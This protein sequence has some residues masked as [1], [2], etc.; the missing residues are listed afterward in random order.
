MLQD[1]EGPCDPKTGELLEQGAMIPRPPVPEPRPKASRFYNFELDEET[2]RPYGKPFKATVPL[3]DWHK[4][5]IAGRLLKAIGEPKPAPAHVPLAKRLEMAAAK[6][7]K[8]KAKGD[9]KT[10]NQGVEK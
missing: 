9:K 1:V 7:D 2:G 3:D 10:K 4:S 5:L 6:G 8:A